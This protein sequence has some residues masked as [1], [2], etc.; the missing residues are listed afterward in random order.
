M[1]YHNLD[2]TVDALRTDFHNHH[3]SITASMARIETKFEVLADK[4]ESLDRAINGDAIERE[5]APSIRSD[6]RSLKS[7]RDLLRK[8]IK[9]AWVV[10]A[11]FSGLICTLWFKVNR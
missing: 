7:S 9:V 8:S 10:T 11:F 3:V 2:A 4:V 5:G 1:D 6:I